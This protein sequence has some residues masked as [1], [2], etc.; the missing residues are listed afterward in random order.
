MNVAVGTLDRLG[1]WLIEAT[2]AVGQMLRFQTQ[3]WRAATRH[4]IR[5]GE[6]ME[7][8][9]EIGVRS[10]MVI[11]LTG[12]FTGL[13]FSL[14]IAYAFGLFQAEALIG[15]T[16]VLSLTRELGPVLAGL[17]VTGRAGS[18]MATEL[19][20]MRITEQI[21]ALHAM[22]VP[23]MAYLV[24]PRVLA[25]TVMLPLLAALFSFVGF[26]GAHAVTTTVIG[27]SSSTFFNQI[28]NNVDLLDIWGG[29]IKAMV[30]G[31]LIALISTQRGFTARGGAKGVGLRTT[32]AVVVANVS[33]LIADYFLTVVIFNV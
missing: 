3:V 31:Y 6:T 11:I 27:V 1:S 30:F 25:T 2:D 21:D 28:L 5:W 4:G 32:Q 26:V 16:V 18:A 7:Q 24:I 9:L 13:V 23:P 19:G 12:L 15:S 29:L 33:I 14:Q 8:A 20:T 17:M 22:G 10:S